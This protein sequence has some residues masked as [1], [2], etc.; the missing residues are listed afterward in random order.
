MK[1]K[2]YLIFFTV[3]SAWAFWTKSLYNDRNALQQKNIMLNGELQTAIKQNQIKAQAFAEREKSLID[4]RKEIENE[5]KKLLELKKT[6][7]HYNSWS[8][9][10]LPDGVSKLL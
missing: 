3:L 10:S 9:D 5:Y 8:D 2:A 7:K 6:D 1:I 4:D